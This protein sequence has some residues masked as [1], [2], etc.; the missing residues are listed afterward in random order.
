MVEYLGG[1]VEPLPVR[2]P[3]LFGKSA[4]HQGSVRNCEIDDCLQIKCCLSIATYNVGSNDNVER[5]WLAAVAPIALKLRSPPQPPRRDASLGIVVDAIEAQIP[6]HALDDG[7][8]AVR[9]RHGGCVEELATYNAEEAGAGAE[10]EH[11]LPRDQF[12]G[13]R[14]Q[15]GGEVECALP[16]PVAGVGR[17]GDEGPRLVQGDG[18]PGLERRAAVVG[19]VCVLPG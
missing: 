13:V 2:V 1:R 12:R 10:L 9:G 6:A 17:A 14:Q 7:I 4:V 11:P 16:G 8:F 3:P 19:E 18:P 15:V 5:R